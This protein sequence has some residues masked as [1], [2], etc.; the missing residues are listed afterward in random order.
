VGVTITTR[1]L[2]LQADT[3]RGATL[4]LREKIT[5]VFCPQLRSPD[6]EESPV[7]RLATVAA[8][9]DVI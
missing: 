9:V 7:H 5:S 3:G 4:G 8:I 2:A 1:S 6:R